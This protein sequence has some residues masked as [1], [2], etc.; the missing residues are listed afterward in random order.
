MER[1]KIIKK[2]MKIKKMK[3]KKAVV[4]LKKPKKV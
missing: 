2:V 1:M 4:I 3:M